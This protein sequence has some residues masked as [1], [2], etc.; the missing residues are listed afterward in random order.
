[1]NTVSTGA[2]FVRMQ[3]NNLA[4]QERLAR[5]SDQVATQKV[6]SDF[7]GLGSGARV[8]INL[9]GELKELDTYSR[10]IAGAQ[11]RLTT[12]VEA[13]ERI[14]QLAKDLSVELIKLQSD[15]NAEVA[16]VNQIARQ[17]YQELT[18][19]LNAKVDGRYVFAGGDGANPPLPAARADAL[20]AQTAT[21]LTG[22]ITNAATSLATTRATAA[23]R[24]WF[25]DTID[26]DTGVPPVPVVPA[27]S[28][29]VDRDLDL[30]YGVPATNGV[31]SDD[32]DLTQDLPYFR[33]F[34]HAFAAAANVD[35]PTTPAELDEL[36]GYLQQVQQGVDRATKRL[37]EEVGALGALGSRMKT[38][39]DRHKDLAVHLQRGV[40]DV[41]DVDMAAAITKL[42]L[43]QTQL[44]ASYRV[45]SS[46]NQVN[47]NDFL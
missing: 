45:T 32:V 15:P 40:S 37:D 16:V 36:R 33:E 5:L 18:S 1:M 13:M 25:A 14:G 30:E 39:D 9:R 24:G 41:E 2:Q 46:L 43:V 38:I 31:Y 29:R 8:S 28:A 44:Q 4:L 17:G 27:V 35:K 20:F 47:L 23:Q 26:P 19:L 11:L 7:A 6:S 42:Q 34:L 10:N 12:Q 21:D 3:A 22:P